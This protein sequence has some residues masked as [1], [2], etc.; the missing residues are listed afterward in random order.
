MPWSLNM[1]DEKDVII[2]MIPDLFKVCEKSLSE[3]RNYHLKKEMKYRLILLS[4]ELKKLEKKDVK[5]K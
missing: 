4:K 3:I 2:G 5:N 1:E